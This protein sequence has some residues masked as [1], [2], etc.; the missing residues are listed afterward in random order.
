MIRVKIC[1]ITTP[2]DAALAAELGASAIGLVFWPG[3][4]RCV[5]IDDAWAIVKG[6]PPLV[7]AIGV[8]VNQGDEPFRVA[9]TVGLSAVQLHG[10]EP[11]ESYCDRGV[12]KIKAIAVGDAQ[13]I[14]AAAAVPGDVSVLLDAH[15]PERR[16]GTGRRVDWAVAAKIAARRPVILSGGLNAANV[17]EAI[18][19]VRPAAID[20]SSGV[21]SA[22]GRKDPAKLRALFD[23]L[24]S[25]LT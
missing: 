21:E 25:S 8:F 23:I 12:P 2:E 18:E 22:P 7:P 16:G 13:A 24:H 5:D 11:P 3:S 15:D 14:V 19:T 4:P 10:D 1:G 20:V 6:L 9:A 17:I